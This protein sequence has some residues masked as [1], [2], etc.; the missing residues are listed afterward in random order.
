MAWGDTPRLPPTQSAI[1]KQH[2][3]MKI[4]FIQQHTREAY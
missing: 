2:L 4:S 3:E 1:W